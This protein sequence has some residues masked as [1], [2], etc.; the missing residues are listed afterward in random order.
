MH[1]RILSATSIAAVAMSV[2]APM[3]IAQGTQSPNAQSPG[4]NWFVPGQA[5]GAAPRNT[6]APGARNLAPR[7]PMPGPAGFD[8]TAGEPDPEPL[9]QLQVQLPPA[10]DIPVLPRAPSPPAAVI[11]VIAVPDVMRASSAAQQ[12]ERVIGER[13]QKLN[14]EAQKEQVAWREIQQQLA[15][16]RGSL[17]PDQ[18]RAKERDLQARITETQRRFRERNRVIQEAVQYSLAQIERT[19][20]GVLQQ[21]AASRGM[22]MILHRA[23]VAL[24]VAEFDVSGQAVAELNKILPSV[25][26]PPDGVSPSAMPPVTQGVPAPPPAATSDAPVPRPSAAPAPGASATAPTG[27]KPKH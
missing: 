24:N 3:A 14:E 2:L 23:Q 18:I 10:P 6:P 20:S 25:I 21:I 13:R 15:A 8:P 5:R 16:Q 26:I 11:G 22:N 19:L 17:T 27:A 7:A 12:I 9:P 1:F 4:Q